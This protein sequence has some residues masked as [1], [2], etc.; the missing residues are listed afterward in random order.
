MTQM[1][2]ALFALAVAALTS[3]AIAETGADDRA[4]IQSVISG[5]IDALRRDDAAGAYAAA[6]PGI[7]QRFPNPEIFMSM[8]AGGYQPV[9]RPKS[10]VF[11][12]LD[13]TPLG[14]IQRLFVVGP[15]GGSYI[16][17]Y[18]MERQRDGAWK[19]NGVV[20]AR[21]NEPSI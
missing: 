18:L 13:E 8:V 19:V 9:Y 5:Q 17:E 3:G 10:F 14:P 11:G 16:A 21:D 12:E 20:L 7:K 15:D 1:L 4:A 6:S 2:A